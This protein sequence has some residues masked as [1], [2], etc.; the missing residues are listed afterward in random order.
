MATQPSAGRRASRLRRA[1][2]LKPILFGILNVTPDSFSDGGRYL[3]P[4]AAVEH[5]RELLDNGADVIDVGAAASNRKAQPVAADEEI[6]RLEPVLATLELAPARLSVD[7]SSGT[8][9]RYALAKGVGF[10][11][12]VTGFRDPK[13]YATLASSA[14]KLI[15]V[16]TMTGSIAAP[17]A[18]GPG[19]AMASAHR[20]FA[21]RIAA[22]TRAGVDEG[23]LVL[24]PGMGLFLGSG[25]TPSVEVLR[26]IAELKRAYRMPLMISVSRKSFLRD[27]TG[28]DVA[29]RGAATLAAELYAA[30]QGADYVRTHDPGALRDAL[31][32][33]A[34]LHSES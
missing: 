10:L 22:L 1:A 13:L 33:L 8:V 15:V 28:R 19:E 26:G 23:R 14:A 21:A 32:V 29:S 6:A 34:A 4:A 3:A 27:L 2:P 5:A 25:A 12:D 30:E 18:T 20:F 31:R 9:Q 11:N 16:H 24:D 17:R 7:S